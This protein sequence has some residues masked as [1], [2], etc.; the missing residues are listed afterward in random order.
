MLSMPGGVPL[1]D[2]PGGFWGLGPDVPFTY[3]D[4]DQFTM[5]GY[6]WV[7][8]LRVGCLMYQYDILIVNI[9]KILEY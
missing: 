1:V 5:E 4:S 8:S 6:N 3:L 2:D 7:A 9:S